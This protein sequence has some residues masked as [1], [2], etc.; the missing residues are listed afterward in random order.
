MGVNALLVATLGLSL[1]PESRDSFVSSTKAKV[2]HVLVAM[3][4]CQQ[5]MNHSQLDREA[6]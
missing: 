6:S 2:M 4:L 1:F 5:M 3:L